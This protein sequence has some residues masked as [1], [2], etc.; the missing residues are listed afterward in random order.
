MTTDIDLEQAR[1]FLDTEAALLDDQDFEGWL[2]LFAPR[3]RY[4]LPIS[5]GLDPEEE[6]AIVNDD[7]ATLDARVLRMRNPATYSQS[8]LSRTSR[9]IGNVLFDRAAPQVPGTVAVRARFTLAECRNRETRMYAGR[10]DHRLT[11]DELGAIRIVEKRVSLV[12]RDSA[13]HCITF[14]W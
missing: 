8:P 2:E 4:W 5:E 10:L 3:C 1:I 14:L 13:L 11:R 6:L 9:L 7:R 12:N